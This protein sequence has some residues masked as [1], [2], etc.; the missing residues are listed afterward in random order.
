MVRQLAPHEAPKYLVEE[1]PDQLDLKESFTS[2][3]RA[4]PGGRAWRPPSARSAVGLDRDRERARS[5]TTGWS[6]RRPGTSVR[7][8]VAIMLGP[9]EK[10]PRRSAD[11][12]PGGSGRTR[13]RRAQL[14]LLPGLHHARL[15]RQDR[16]GIV[17]VRHQRNG[18]NSDS[19]EHRSGPGS[20]PG[21]RA[22]RARPRHRLAT[23]C[24]VT[25]ASARS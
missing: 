12:R 6:R 21:P 23:C 17:E 8:T 10:A 19:S 13:S 11:H 15:R 24:A 7:V 18:V 4:M 3:D 16:Q 9:M 1:V 14:R 2:T 5:R 25:T 20:R 22:A